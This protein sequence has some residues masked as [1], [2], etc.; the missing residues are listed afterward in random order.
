MV[1]YC[2]ALLCLLRSVLFLSSFFLF[3]LFLPPL[4]CFVGLL[5]LVPIVISLFVCLGSLHTILSVYLSTCLSLCPSVC[6]SRF[7]SWSL[8]QASDQVCSACFSSSQ[9]QANQKQPPNKSPPI[10][11]IKYIKNAKV[12]KAKSFFFLFSKTTHIQLCVFFCL[13]LFSAS[14]LLSKLSL[15][16]FFLS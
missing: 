5:R 4:Y 7:L 9:L 14:V 16:L 13:C 1:L 10:I 12:S 8:K 11:K 15:W 2:F 3:W 6:F